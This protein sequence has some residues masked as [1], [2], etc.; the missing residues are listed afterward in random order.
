MSFSYFQAHNRPF[1]Q[2]FDF[3][4]KPLEMGKGPNVPSEIL[5]KL[6]FFCKFLHLFGPTCGQP[7]A[8]IQV[9]VSMSVFAIVFSAPSDVKKLSIFLPCSCCCCCCCCCC[10]R[11]VHNIS[12]LTRSPSLSAGV[13]EYIYI[14]TYTY[15]SIYVCIHLWVRICQ[16][17]CFDPSTSLRTRAN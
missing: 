5:L 6:P 11:C 8:R 15:V 1:S 13:G 14:Y 10:C 4:W 16:I 7:G 3:F 17:P 9:I 12:A 2:V